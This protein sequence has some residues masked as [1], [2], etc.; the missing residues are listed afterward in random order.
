MFSA[1]G[2]CH[3]NTSQE[4]HPD[5]DVQSREPE[6]DKDETT[7]CTT[8]NEHVTVSGTDA[9]TSCT[10]CGEHVPIADTDATTSWTARDEHVTVAC[11]DETSSCTDTDASKSRIAVED[12][13]W[14]VV[15]SEKTP[16]LST[17]P[18][19]E[20][21]CLSTDL[22]SERGDKSDSLVL[23]FLVSRQTYLARGETR[24]TDRL[25]NGQRGNETETK[26]PP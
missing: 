17:Q 12:V 23:K 10:A 2:N 16:R 15:V 3:D 19:I 5:T 11:T 14:S 24:V 7:S 26:P 13:E 4:P 1:I 21:P 9:I 25:R 6:S 20:V 18:G 8:H 22:P